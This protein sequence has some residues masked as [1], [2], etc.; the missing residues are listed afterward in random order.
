MQRVGWWFKQGMI[1][2]WA[3]IS[4]NAVEGA[5][6]KRVKCKNFQGL[7]TGCRGKVRDWT[8]NAQGLLASGN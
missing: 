5:D 8:N 2:S 7:A 4:G 3:S 1:R 6:G